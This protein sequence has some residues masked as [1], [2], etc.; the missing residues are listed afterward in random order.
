M[1]LQELVRQH[2]AVVYKAF[3]DR[4]MFCLAPEHAG[5]FEMGL[6]YLA[7]AESYRRSEQPFEDF[8]DPLLYTVVTDDF[9]S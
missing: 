3:G 2:E 4:L 7:G 9:L 8:H 1:L 6:G 5:E